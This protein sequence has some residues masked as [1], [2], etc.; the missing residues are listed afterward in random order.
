MQLT[1]PA[2][3]PVNTNFVL[4]VIASPPP[5]AISGYATEILLP[6]GLQWMPRANCNLEALAN[7]V[8]G[9]NGAVC[10]RTPPAGPPPAGTDVR[11]VT[12]SAIE[13]PPLPAFDTPLV[14]GSHVIDDARTVTFLASWHARD[15]RPPSEAALE[16]EGGEERLALAFGTKAS[17]TWRVVLPEERECR[18]YR[19]RFR[20]AEPQPASGLPDR[21][22]AARAP[23]SG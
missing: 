17:G 14:S 7:R 10:T 15:G 11:H 23:G 13:A 3:A 20:D 6:A 8:G 16:I 1:A 18:R 21:P 9:S 4:N 2:S 19:F 12:A 22:G 5:G